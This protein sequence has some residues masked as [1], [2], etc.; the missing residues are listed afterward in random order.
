MN[1]DQLL[2]ETRL[3]L[4]HLA[5]RQDVSP[6]TVWRWTTRG[7]SGHVLE[8]FNVGGK[9]FTTEEAFQRWIIAQNGGPQPTPGYSKRREREIA[10]AERELKKRGIL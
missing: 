6:T 7:V 4:S 2:R 10:A 5:R 1:F 8:S 9:R 3:Q